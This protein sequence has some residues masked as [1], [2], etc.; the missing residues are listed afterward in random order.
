MISDYYYNYLLLV[1]MPSTLHGSKTMYAGMSF[2]SFLY[3]CMRLLRATNEMSLYTVTTDAH[4][5]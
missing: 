4:I 3:Y 5:N 2:S 1:F